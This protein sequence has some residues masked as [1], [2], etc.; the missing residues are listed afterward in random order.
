MASVKESHSLMS[1]ARRS[2]P[3]LSRTFSSKPWLGEVLRH[4]VDGGAVGVLEHA[5][6]VDVAEHGYLGPN[7]L[8]DLVVGAADDEVGLDAHRAQLLDGVLGGLGLDLV[9]GRDVGHQAAVDDGDVAG[10]LL[11]A[12]LAHGLDEGL[13]LDVADGAA[14]LGDHDVGTG[15]LL[16]AQEALLDG[17]GDVGDDLDGAAEVVSLAL[18]GDERLVDEARCE[19]GVAREVL[20]DEA[21]VVA[22]VEVGL[23]AV[24]GD[25]DLA[26]L[27]RAHRAGI[28]VEVGV[29]LLHHDLVAAGLEKT[30]QRGRR[31]ALAEGGYDAASYEDVLGHKLIPA[32]PW[33]R[34]NGCS[35]GS[36]Y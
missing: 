27:E 6:G 17:V 28:D 16:D 35:Y 30:P 5:V 31:D 11:L 19:V 20:V 25:E 8:L 34:S 32:L 2:R 12:E 33:V 15:L 21:L 36:S 24:L 29:G 9:G 22:E 1:L 4:L 23:L 26:V 3:S 7:R 14:E 13:S 18:A 10:T